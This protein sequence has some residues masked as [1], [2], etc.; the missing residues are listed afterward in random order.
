MGSERRRG[1]LRLLACRITEGCQPRPGPAIRSLLEFD[2][3]R[4]V[5]CIGAQVSQ[6][7]M[8]RTRYTDPEAETTWSSRPARVYS[9][10]NDLNSVVSQSGT[11]HPRCPD[12][13]PGIVPDRDPPSI[14]DVSKSMLQRQPRGFRCRVKFGRSCCHLTFAIATFGHV[15]SVGV[16]SE[17]NWKP[18]KNASDAG[19][20]I[21]ATRCVNER[22]RTARCRRISG[23]VERSWRRW[24]ASHP[25][26]TS[27]HA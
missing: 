15:A 19:K 1:R 12:S 3:R 24:H 13:P 25:T 6:S 4:A 21:P 26:E 14:E 2:R 11:L 8:R 7:R 9:G 16:A 18:R 17:H 20:I 22:C 27:C 5:R 10:A 23:S